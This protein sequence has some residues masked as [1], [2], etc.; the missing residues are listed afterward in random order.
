MPVVDNSVAAALLS[1]PPRGPVSRPP[2]PPP[3]CPPAPSCSTVSP[4][5]S[6]RSPRSPPSS[7]RP[8][9]DR[10]AA[11]GR[12]PAGPG[13]HAGR[14]DLADRPVRAGRGLDRPLRP[15]QSPSCCTARRRSPRPRRPAWWPL[16]PRR[17]PRAGSCPTHRGHFLPSETP[18]AATPS[19][20]C[21]GRRGPL[22]GSQL[23]P[24]PVPHRAAAPHGQRSDAPSEDR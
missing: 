20:G 2:P 9:A 15:S 13:Q 16:S 17:L 22:P 3:S 19:C 4:S 18:G 24:R 23:V 6:P 10:A 11:H 5:S 7:C 1:Y 21:C 12:R 8:H 14:G